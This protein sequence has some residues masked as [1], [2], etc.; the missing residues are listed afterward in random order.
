MRVLYFSRDYTTHD[1]HFLDRLAASPYEIYFLRLEADGTPYETHPL[2]QQ[3]HAVEWAGGRHP[4]VTPDEWFHL[5]PSFED[6]VKRVRPDLIHAGPVQSC[7]FMAAVIGFRPLLLMSWGSDLL[8]HADRD[9]QW[10]WLTHYTLTRTDMLICDSS[11]VRRKAQSLVTLPDDRI[12]QFPWGVDL[13]TFQAGAQ[14]QAVRRQLGW[15]DNRVVVST[16]AW[17]EPYGIRVLLQAFRLAYQSDPGLR[18][19]LLATGSARE[20]VMDTIARP[21]LKEAIHCPGQIP[22]S[23]LVSYFQ[24]ADVYI[25][26]AHSDGTSISLLEALAVGLPVVVT[27]ISSNREWVTPGVNGWLG[28]DNDPASFAAALLTAAHLTEADR[29]ALHRRNR[30]LAEERADWSHNVEKLLAAYACLTKA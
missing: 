24:A 26:C 1:F 28:T 16:R 27:D 12:V 22:H 23:E 29:M 8:V 18:L 17:E 30:T 9:A 19:L 10:R 4:A 5:L 3:I 20:T 25:S 6:V 2:P 14:G 11:A 21:E 7:G 15:N 13:H